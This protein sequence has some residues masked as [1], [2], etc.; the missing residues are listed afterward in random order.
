MRTL[1]EK[2]LHEAQLTHMQHEKVR[3]KNDTKLCAFPVANNMITEKFRE[4]LGP[5]VS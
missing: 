4:L 1:Y 2:A 5:L 3:A